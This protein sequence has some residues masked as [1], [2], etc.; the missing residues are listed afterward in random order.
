LFG[1]AKAAMIAGRPAA[2]CP[3]LEESQ[4]LDPRGGTA[5]LLALCLERTGSLARA[6]RAFED[7]VT[8]ARRDAAT[9][10]Q[11][12]AEAHLRSLTAR[13]PRVQID[14]APEA[15]SLPGATLALDGVSLP[16]DSWGAALP[17]DP[18]VH[19]ARLEA[20]GHEAAWAEVRVTE[21]GAVWHLRLSLTASRPSPPAD[22]TPAPRGRTVTLVWSLGGAAA[23]S[24][25]VGAY[26]GLSAR[27]KMRE[28][29]AACPASP[30]ASRDAEATRD[31]AARHAR[32]STW[33]FA[34]AAALGAGAVWAGAR[35][36]RAGAAVSLGGEF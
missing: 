1:D 21:G 19:T 15:A 24:A 2:A 8:W 10:R 25:L 30:C 28:V 7:A 11:A 18:G 5:L 16:M 9:G 32:A 12:L 36:D 17:V 20:P 35:A 3:M 23:A 29:R 14:V 4:R 26:F 33:S 31:A 13:V 6:L 22:P 34:A 27:E